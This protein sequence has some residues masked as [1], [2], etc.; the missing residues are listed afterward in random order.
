MHITFI[1]TGGTIDKDYPHT[2]K[3]WAF[4]FGEPA[5]HRILEKL[6]PAF[7]YEVV[8]ACQKDSLEITDE[9]RQRMVDL[10]LEEDCRQVI[11]TH[12]TDTMLETA[13]YLAE[14]LPDRLI[15]LT[16]AM[17]PER[18][19]N[20]EAPINLG[21]AIATANLQDQGVFIAMHGIVKEHSAMQRDPETG[22][23]H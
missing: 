8:T 2:S 22:K 17:R 16:G 20:S 9:D 13:A 19:T 14:R 11:L 21:A 6:D 7:D 4:E 1:Q 15:V 3:G 12:G 5:T 10:I 18:F 23:Y